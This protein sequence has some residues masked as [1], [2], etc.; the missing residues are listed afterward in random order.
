[1]M[2]R[3]R[4][5]SF[6]S[7]ALAAAV[8]MPST[9]AAACDLDDLVGYKIVAKVVIAGYVDEAGKQHSGYFGC[10]A[11]RILVF[12]DHTGVRCK[13]EGRQEAV[14]PTAF[15][16][17]RSQDDLKLCVGDELYDVVSPR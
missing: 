11:G 4:R 8:G 6:L 2:L 15:L 7:L 10:V 12:T 13:G 5:N 9:F 16:F 1:M 17:A 14:M 3:W